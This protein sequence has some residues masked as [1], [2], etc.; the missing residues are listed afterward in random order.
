[1]KKWTADETEK[2][3]CL[4]ILQEGPEVTQR[5][6]SRFLEYRADENSLQWLIKSVAQCEAGEEKQD[7]ERLARAL[8]GARKHAMLVGTW[9]GRARKQQPEVERC[10]WK[11]LSCGAVRCSVAG[12]HGHMKL[13][14]RKP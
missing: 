10:G 9:R 6:T 8:E 12:I 11:C 5:I 14:W 3:F 1:M 2:L 4:A 7:A 13:C